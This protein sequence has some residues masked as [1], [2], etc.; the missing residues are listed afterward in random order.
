[1][2]TAVVA[3][4][5]E[6]ADVVARDITAI[7][8]RGR[9]KYASS[10]VVPG[11][12]VTLEAGTQACQEGPSKKKLR[13]RRIKE[14]SPTPPPTPL[15]VSGGNAPT[16]VTPDGPPP[17]GGAVRGPVELPATLQFREGESLKQ[18]QR[19]SKKLFA[20]NGFLTVATQLDEAV[21]VQLRD[22]ISTHVRPPPPPPPPPAKKT[23]ASR[24]LTKK[25]SHNLVDLE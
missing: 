18:L 21:C 6:T 3:V 5:Q 23:T 7:S 4:K 17:P 19:R 11:H 1:V 24:I 13:G 12:D 10:H 16:S 8:S 22:I 14:H 9:V 15:S 2:A 25:K 20:D